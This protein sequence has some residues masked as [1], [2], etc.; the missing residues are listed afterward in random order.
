MV[1]YRLSALICGLVLALG[2]LVPSSM[3]AEPV[4]AFSWYRFGQ[5]GLGA[6][7]NSGIA[8]M[9]IYAGELYAGTHNS[10][11]GC[12]VHRYD[13]NTWTEVAAGGF[14][15][16]DNIEASAMAVYDSK[17]Y[18]GTDNFNSGCQ[19][20]SYDGST[21]TQEGGQ[22]T[23][24]ST[25][26]PS[27][28]DGL[29]TR[30]S[31][32]AVYEGRF[33][34]G[35]SN[36]DGC[37]V[38]AYDGTIW[39]STSSGGFGNADL[40]DAASMA[41]YGPRLY[42]GTYDNSWSEGCEVWSYNG[43]D[44]MQEIGEGDPG[45]PTAPGFGNKDNRTA[46][47]MAVYGSEL[48]VGTRDSSGSK[49]CE[50]WFYNGT[51]W[52]PITT[53]GFGDTRNFV[54]ESLVANGLDLYVGTNNQTTGCEVWGFDGASWTQ[55]S[56]D[57]FGDPNNIVTTRMVIDGNTL[58]AGT[59]NSTNG[60]ETW[61][62]EASQVLYFAEGYT[63][64][65]F[66][67][68]LCLGNSSFNDVRVAVTYM[69]PDGNMQTQSLALPAQSRDTV[70]VNEMVGPDKEVSVKVESD[71]LIV[72]ERP[73]YFT[74]SGI[75]PGGHDCMGTPD[76]SRTWYFAEGYTGMGFEEWICVLNP[77]NTAADLTFRFQT[78][79]EGEL[80]RTGYNVPAYSRGSFKVNEVLGADYQ[81]SLKIES[82]SPVV[83]ERPMY[84]DYL[85]TT[86]AHHW[87]GGHCVM[88]VPFLGQSYFFA[89]GTTRNGFE[90]WLTLQNPSAVDI[91][92]NATYQLGSGQGDAVNSTYDVPA[93]ERYTVYVPAE[94]G[95]DKDVST[96]LFSTSLFL[97]ERPMYFRYTGYDANRPGGHCVIGADRANTL[98]LFAEGYTG[99]GFHTWL[100]L[101]NP[102]T[103]EAS[104]ALIYYTQ[105]EGDLPA[106]FVDVP[107]GS[108][109][110][111]FVNENAGPNYQLSIEVASDRDIVVERPMY[112]DFATNVPGGHDVVG[113]A[114]DT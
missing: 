55:E 66:F 88:G 48:F 71:D 32:M 31:S 54:A 63:G 75:W 64:A 106:R 56:P 61:L 100:T 43:T 98:W 52:A 79:E 49:G 50:V 105:E 84:F 27:F 90:E 51:D 39:E 81:N 78:H 58:Y 68:Y 37:Q 112:F 80:V 94:V 19:L 8:S 109:Y 44:W 62:T 3:V 102:G 74:Y 13:V 9:A 36:T 18:V 103:E 28:V 12:E 101:Q 89:E 108:R 65:S 86:G 38:W 87:Q 4:Q 15:D 92:V 107:A 17:L 24:A 10:T 22:V 72:A 77:G 97:A 91:T 57:G 33:Y 7:E 14:G 110:T 46:Q 59:H 25:F 6:V 21:W 53:G 82:S 111:V 16:A 35:T 83:A 95:T 26:G 73:M 47:S 23:P 42:V 45:T 2:L 69:F 104:V 5:G 41:V 60:C 20:W 34:I 29:N 70:L 1:R 30:I 93:G 114:C 11:N 67:E 40:D 113:Y 85:G 99:A 96:R 76:A